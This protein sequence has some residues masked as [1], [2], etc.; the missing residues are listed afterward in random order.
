MASTEQ[1]LSLEENTPH[2][3]TILNILNR[4][5]GEFFYDPA[6][7]GDGK[8]WE[9][10]PIVYAD[11][12]P[13]PFLFRDNPEEALKKINGRI[14][15]KVKNPYVVK[16]EDKRGK[17]R[18][19][20][21]LDIQDQ[22][23]LDSFLRG[24]LSP[25][26]AFL[27]RS[28]WDIID[29]EVVRRLKEI[30]PNHVLIFKEDLKRKPRDMGAITANMGEDPM[31][32]KKSTLRAFLKK[33]ETLLKEFPDEEDAAAN[34]EESK[35]EE[36]IMADEISKLSSENAVLMKEKNDLLGQFDGLKNEI[37]T[38]DEKIKE[39]E[40]LVSKY[41]TAEEEA[42]KKEMEAKWEK[43][44]ASLPVGKIHNPEE[45]ATL[46][47]LFMENPMD[48]AVNMAELKTKNVP[49]EAEG[50]T[51]A[52]NSTKEEGK[53]HVGSYDP[54]TRSWKPLSKVI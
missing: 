32:D 21:I 26:T 6:A 13:D 35:K 15:G 18:L 16:S 14:V 31:S 33:L 47:K 20:G 11:T 40:A 1:N 30:L 29:G 42:K 45:E 22:E 39:L 8:N 28:D 53:I 37:T 5:H 25:S 51:Y 34:M 50:M 4:Q 38:K 3:E 36:E 54:S 19:M 49:V 24:E 27:N 12:H 52:E 17:P 2:K 48:F 7:F 9:G 44:K 41:R 10:V 46:K 43:V 23:V